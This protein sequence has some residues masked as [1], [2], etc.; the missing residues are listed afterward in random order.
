MRPAS[1]EEV[2]TAYEAGLRAQNPAPS[3]LVWRLS[4]FD[5]GLDIITELRTIH[6]DLGGARVADLGA[7]H[8][9]DCCAFITA[10]ALPIA[11][12]YRNHGY[13][14][15]R[16]CLRSIGVP[17]DVV[18]ADATS[19]LPFTPRSLDGVL[20]LNLIE[21]IPN[22]REF[23]VDLW[24]VLE[25]G[26]FA[27]LTTPLAWRHV[28]RDPF[29]GSPI[30]AL[31][32]MPIRRFVAERVLGRRYPFTLRGKTCYSSAGLLAM[33]AHVG[34]LASA[35]KYSASPLM[36][37]V[38]HWPLPRL[39]KALVERYAFDFILLRK[40]PLRTMARPAVGT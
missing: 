27:V 35:G 12:D 16:E 1:V 8:G 26:G 40:Q 31:L 4:R 20:A 19:T 3:E 15:T 5:R 28:V 22:R 38:R 25:P 18:L 9:G 14:P 29:Y 11:V 6:G 37:R 39:W 32:P 34:F 21:H 33:A 23:L 36:S 30:T 13:G 17:F 10:G 24:R 7:G 2:R